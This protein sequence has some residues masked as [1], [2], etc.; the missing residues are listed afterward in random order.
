MIEKEARYFNRTL[1]HIHKVQKNAFYLITNYSFE[2][3]L[4]FEECRQFAEQVMLHDRSK[5]SVIQCVPYIELTEYYHQRKVL[6]NKDYDYPS[7]SVRNAVDWA[8][9]DHYK[10][11][12]HHPEKYKGKAYCFTKLECLEIICDL[13]A[14]AQEFNEGTCKDFFNNVWRPKHLKYFQSD[15]HVYWESMHIM[16]KAISFFELASRKGDEDE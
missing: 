5:F 7:E 13:Q 9:E 14:M 2:L 4:T 8:V 16:Y 10:Q 11:E 15:D 12:N 6:G 1:E 3:G